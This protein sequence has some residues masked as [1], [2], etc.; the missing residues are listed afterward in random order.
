[1]RNVGEHTDEYAIDKGRNSKVSRTQLQVSSQ[2]GNTY[3]WLDH[4]I[5]IDDALRAAAELFIVVRDVFDSYP[6][7]SSAFVN[8]APAKQ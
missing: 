7:A 6:I 5:N 1:M 4:Q 3:T 2:Q 8:S